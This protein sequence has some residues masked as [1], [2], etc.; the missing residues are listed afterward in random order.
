[1][2]KYKITILEKPVMMADIAVR[3][4]LPRHPPFRFGD[5]QYILFGVTKG[6]G[7]NIAATGT[8]CAK[9]DMPHFNKALQIAI[10]L[11]TREVEIEGREMEEEFPDML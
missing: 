2:Q 8:L 9:E 6:G 4:N 5:E 7:V 10:D 11:A 3:L 1:M